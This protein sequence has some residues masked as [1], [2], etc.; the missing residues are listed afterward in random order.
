MNPPFKYWVYLIGLIFIMNCRKPYLPPAVAASASY[1]VVEGVINTGSDSTVIKLSQTVSLKGKTTANP[2]HGATVTVESNQNNTYALT[3]T[4]TGQYASPGLNLSNSLQ[5]RLRIKTTSEEYVSDF[6]PVVNSPAIDTVSHEVRADGIQFSV[7]THDP[8]NNTH[9]YRWD[10]QETWTIH[11]KYYSFYKSNGDTVLDRDLLHDQIYQCWQSDTSSTIVIGTSG[12]LSQ[13]IISNLPVTF[14]PSASP[15]LDGGQSIIISQYAPTASCYSIVVKQYG[16]TGDAYRFWTNLKKNTEQLG[17]IFDAEPSQI[18]GNIHSVTHPAEPV[19][20]YVSAGSVAS[21]RIFVTNG[22][23][24]VA[25]LPD[26]RNSDCVLDTLY[27]RGTPPGSAVEVNEE[28][29][30]FNYNKQVKYHYLQ[31]PI[32][33][34]INKVNGKVIGHTGSTPGCV[35]CTLRG[36]NI[37]PSFWK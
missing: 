30:Y 34:I 15:K 1:L 23:I 3:E 29:E 22:E 37:Q 14:V 35:D 36:T 13:D 11:S 32:A 26:L 10:Y 25:W 31:I 8:Q 18:D 33:V 17:S 9:Y 20:G 19:I 28:D 27:F 5:Y 12:R 2:V 7:S 21:K 24:P 4:K 16:L 6:V